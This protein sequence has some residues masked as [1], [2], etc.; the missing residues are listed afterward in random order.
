MKF[1]EA[2][3]HPSGP[4]RARNV[5]WFCRQDD[6]QK[7]EPTRRNGIPDAGRARPSAESGGRQTPQDRDTLTDERIN[8]LREWIAAGGHNAPDVA[9]EVARRILDRGEI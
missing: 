4:G 2:G 6:T 9:E 1:H 7:P 5:A 8:A 3:T